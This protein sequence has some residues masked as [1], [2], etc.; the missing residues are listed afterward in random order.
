MDDYVGYVVEQWMKENTLQVESGIRADVSESFLVGLKNLFEEHYVD[1]PDEKYDILEDLQ[2]KISSL[3]ESLEKE[4][5]NNVTLRKDV[6]ESK[7]EEVFSDCSHGMVDTDV[8]KLRKLSEGIEF[9]DSDQYREK[10]NIIKESYFG[11]SATAEF[12]FEGKP[13]EKTDLSESMDTYSR[14]LGKSVKSSKENT[15]S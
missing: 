6:L 2:N 5:E 4:L 10:I 11:D 9:E 15:L 14:Y 8:D 13:E 3:E 12:E 1:I 7:C